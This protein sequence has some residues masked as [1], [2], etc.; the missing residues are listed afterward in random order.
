MPNNIA[1]CYSNN[2]T[3][4]VDRNN[5]QAFSDFQQDNPKIIG[6]FVPAGTPFIMRNDSTVKDWRKARPD[7]ICPLNHMQSLP[8]QA[9]RKIALMDNMFGGDNLQALAN[10]YQAELTPLIR[11]ES[12]GAIGAATTALESRLS[13]FGKAAKELQGALEKV[14]AGAKAKYPKAQMIKLEQNARTLSKD[15]NHKF[16]A[17]IN[18]YVGRVKNKKGTVYNNAQRG[19][20]VAKSGRSIKP[21]QFTSTVDFQNLRA[22]EKGANVL[23]KGLFV[24]DAGIR[25]GNVHSD[26]LAGRDW[27]KRAVVETAGFGTAGAFGLIAGGA[28]VEAALGIALLA[29]PVGWV[30]IIG[31]GI[32]VGY[33]AAKVGDGLGQDAAGYL[34]DK[35]STGSWL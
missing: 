19:V 27:Q 4:P 20:N 31:A 5:S 26:Y 15:F 18:K 6:G 2:N 9:K 17:E 10:F 7:L 23:S 21:I 8:Q 30:I 11:N 3:Y 24:I 35:S 33:L 25:A 34:Y 14:R 29:T 16:K 12:I 13:E 1:L 28:V 22:F 32:T